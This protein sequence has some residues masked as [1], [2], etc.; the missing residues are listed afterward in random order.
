MNTHRILFVCPA[1][2]VLL[3]ASTRAAD[4]HNLEEGLPTEIEDA[5]PVGFRGREVQAAFRYERTD[6]NEDRFVIDPRV[7]VGFAPNWQ[8]KVSV[9]FFLGSADRTDSGNVG[10]EA[11]YN[12]NVE[13]LVLPAFALSGRTDF[14]TGKD[15]AGLDTTLKAIMT[16]SISKTGLDRIHLNLAWKHNA[17]SRHGQR[18][19]LYRLVVGYSRR[20]D[21]DTTVMVDFIREQEVEDDHEANL[22]ELGVRRQIT[23]RILVGLGVGAGVGDESPKFRTTLA[24]QKSF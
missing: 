1:L 8:A 13:G 10:L 17:G 21:A 2:L 19:D 15:S 18:D 16:K 5:Y 24:L 6:D 3:A 11:F 23:P 4:H 12:F 9:P 14:P 20:L 22:F 7:E